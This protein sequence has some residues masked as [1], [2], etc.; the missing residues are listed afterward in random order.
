[1]NIG[2]LAHI[3]RGEMEAKGLDRTDQAIKTPRAH[4]LATVR[5]EAIGDDPQVGDESSSI[6]V[7][8]ARHHRCKCGA[9]AG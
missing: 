7:S 6:G 1:M 8:I 9:F 4:R 2:I 3:K 5:F